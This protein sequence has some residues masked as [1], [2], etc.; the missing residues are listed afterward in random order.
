LARVSLSAA[1]LSIAAACSRDAAPPSD[2]ADP[3]ARDTSLVATTGAANAPAAPAP[4]PRASTA[5]VVAERGAWEPAPVGAAAFEVNRGTRGMSSQLRWLLSPDSS[6]LLVIDDPNGVENE[7]VPDAVFYATERTGRT[8]RMD[9]VWSAAPSPD[10][11]HLAVGRAVV[12]GGGEKQEVPRGA[13]DAPARR[14]REIAGVAAGE[15]PALSGDSLRAH[16]YAVSGMGVAEGAGV[17]L[18]LEPGALPDAT[19]RFL[20]LDGW[21]V[22]WSCDARSVVIGEKPSRAGDDDSAATSRRVMLTAGGVA[23]AQRDEPRWSDGP[24]TMIG[25]PTPVQARPLVVRGRTID[26]R[27]G[28][29]VVRPSDGAAKGTERDVGPGVPLAATRGGHFILALVPRAG[30]SQ[31]AASDHAVVY[32]VP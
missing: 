9:S 25:V 5:C 4:E 2:S 30:A 13:W 26:S 19:P 29:V 11:R 23:T 1:I 20:S 8:W 32:R 31:P 17:T 27:A 15:T 10:W 14:L 28:R 12:I 16:S 6:A 21:R 18:V 7:P 22:G 3:L 24:S